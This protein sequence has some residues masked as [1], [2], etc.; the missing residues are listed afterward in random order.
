MDPT[1]A[2]ERARDD[3]CRRMHALHVYASVHAYVCVT[4]YDNP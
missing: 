4:E 3:V 1:D 2:H